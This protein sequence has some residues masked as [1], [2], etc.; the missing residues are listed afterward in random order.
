MEQPWSSA[1][2]R[3]SLM[4]HNQHLPGYHTAKRTDQCAFGAVDEHRQPVLKSTGLEANF[5][6]R[7]CIRRCHG[8]RGVPHTPLQGQVNGINRTA[9]AAVYPMRFCKA[10]MEDILY[11]PEPRGALRRKHLDTW[12]HYQVL[13]TCERCRFGRAAMAHMEHNFLPGECRYGKWPEGLNQRAMA[14]G[15]SAPLILQ[16]TSSGRQEIIKVQTRSR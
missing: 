9:M 8:H 7:Q 14:K 2:W 13:Y 15:A 6:L 4:I 3:E 5:R 10:I 11:Y 1:M 12:T 16:L